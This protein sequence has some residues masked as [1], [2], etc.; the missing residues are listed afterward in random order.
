MVPNNVEVAP[1]V[2][3]LPKPV[4]KRSVISSF[5]LLVKG[6]QCPLGFPKM[7]NLQMSVILQQLMSGTAP[8]SLTP[9]FSRLDGILV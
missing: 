7:L 6:L 2:F 5:F 8:D 1:V 3:N 9:S 4:M